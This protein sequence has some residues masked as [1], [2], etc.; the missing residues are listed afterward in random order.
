M[1]KVAYQARRERQGALVGD[2]FTSFSV[3]RGPLHSH[4]Q[5]ASATTAG[6]V[7][8]A[9]AQCQGSPRGTVRDAASRAP[10]I[11]PAVY[12]PVTGPTRS[13]NRARTSGGSSAPATAMPT[14]TSAVA[15]YRQKRSGT[16]R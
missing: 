8:A 2:P 10:P 4:N 15:A 5:P 13:G 1:K 9:S 14:P 11:S 12:R 7:Q 16:A 6:T 3:K